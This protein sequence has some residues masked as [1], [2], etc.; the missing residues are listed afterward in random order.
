MSWTRASGASSTSGKP[1]LNGSAAVCSVRCP[2]L[3]LTLIYR[4][5]VANTQDR[6]A[7][8]VL[9]RSHGGDP[10][11]K[12][13]WLA[14]LEAYREGVLR[15]A[16]LKRGETLLDVGTG[17]GLIAFGALPLLGDAG[18]VIFS[19]ISTELLDH[20]RALASDMGV[21]DRCEFVL[22][23]ADDLSELDDESVD[24]VTTRSVLIY[25]KAKDRAFREFHRVLREGGRVSLF[26][27]INRHF[28]DE[29]GSY[30]GF[31]VADVLDLV[32]KLET[33]YHTSDKDDP[34]PMM[35]FDE[36][37]LFRMAEEAG[38]RSVGLDLEIRREPGSW[39][40][41]WDALLKSAGNPLDPTLEESMRQV[42]SAE[43]AERFERHVRPQIERGR[44]VK[45]SA[46]AFLFAT[47]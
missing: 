3:I 5:S 8:W 17:D 10:V 45:K 30:W 36:R 11:Q 2:T 4:R 18:R 7:R 35:D 28:A 43:E 9:E 37:D 22:T 40:T 25:V 46:F 16:H 26:E 1:K 24:V 44:G 12:R 31:D 27:P 32:Q 14:N 38:F 15:R 6:W 13:A 34:G 42:F 33:T 47:K 20:C 21:L 29:P 39:V 41:S 23:S 19:D